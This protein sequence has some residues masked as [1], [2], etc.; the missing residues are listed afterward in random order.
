[1]NHSITETTLVSPIRAILL[2]LSHPRSMH[3]IRMHGRTQGKSS[4]HPS[5]HPPIHPSIHP[6]IRQWM[7][8]WMDGGRRWPA[9]ATARDWR[10]RHVRVCNPLHSASAQLRMLS[11]TWSVR[12]ALIPSRALLLVYSGDSSS[13]SIPRQ[14]NPP[15]PPPHNNQLSHKERKKERKKKRKKE[16]KEGRN[17]RPI[18]STS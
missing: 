9:S 16:R 1:M 8:G 6:S 7:D 2:S 12:P 10:W 11:I 15:P 18:L 4:I 3:R 5:T 14:K 17:P 13:P